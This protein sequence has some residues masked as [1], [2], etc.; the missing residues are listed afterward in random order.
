MRPVDSEVDVAERKV[1]VDVGEFFFDG[2][3]TVAA[4]AV[5]PVPI[6]ALG[7]L[8]FQRLHFGLALGE[9]ACGSGDVVAETV[10]VLDRSGLVE[11]A[12]A[13]ELGERTEAL[14][15]FP[16]GVEPAVGP[17]QPLLGRPDAALG[18]A[19]IVRAVSRSGREDGLMLGPF[20]EELL[21]GPGP[22]V[23]RK[24]CVG[25][26]PERVGSALRWSA[27]FPPKST[28]GTGATFQ[29]WVGWRERLWPT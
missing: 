2:A 16:S 10:D 19:N 23:G 8:G 25:A 7:G 1:A 28:S 15:A 29:V 3:E 14:E 4:P 27:R 13:A 20:G 11:A 18:A 24:T 9:A 6:S 17:V 21:L 26:T 5:V 12:P 22:V